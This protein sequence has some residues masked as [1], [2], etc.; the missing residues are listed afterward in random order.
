MI[1]NPS[2]IADSSESTVLS[3]YLDGLPTLPCPCCSIVANSLNRCPTDAGD[4]GVGLRPGRPDSDDVQ[5]TSLA[6]IA[7]ID[8]VAPFDIFASMVA[9][10]DVGVTILVEAQRKKTNCRVVVADCKAHKCLF[11]SSRVVI[12]LVFLVSAQKPVA[13][14]ELPVVFRAV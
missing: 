10:C 12:P 7:N 11:A 5:I 14:L 8:V 1:V 13:V 3:S 6:P 4:V 2:A 9:Y